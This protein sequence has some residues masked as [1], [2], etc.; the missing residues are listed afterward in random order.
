MFARSSSSRSPLHS[1]SQR[2]FV[3]NPGSSRTSGNR[4]R[5]AFRRRRK[6]WAPFRTEPDPRPSG[7]A[8]ADAAIAAQEGKLFMAPAPCPPTV[9]TLQ[10][11]KPTGRK[12]RVSRD[13]KAQVGA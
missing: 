1:L 5:A 8:E 4:P 10:K 12:V 6:A 2:S 9:T 7:H 3:P 13:C 11:S